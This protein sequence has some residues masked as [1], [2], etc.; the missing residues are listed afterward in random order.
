MTAGEAPAGSNSKAAAADDKQL[1][2]RVEPEEPIEPAGDEQL[3]GTTAIGTDGKQGDGIEPE[4]PIE[5][6]GDGQLPGTIGKLEPGTRKT[7]KQQLEAQAVKQ[8]LSGGSSRVAALSQLCHL[9]QGVWI[10]HEPQHEAKQS[11]SR[12]VGAVV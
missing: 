5:P 2:G 3:P 12:V 8:Q 7:H 11:G 10:T 1:G 9:S 6:M 4:V